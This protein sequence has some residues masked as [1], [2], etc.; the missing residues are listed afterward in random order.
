[1]KKDLMEMVWILDR[2]GSMAGLE[3]DTVGG[4]NSMVE[5]QRQLPGEVYVS[6]VLFNHQ[7]K[8][9]HDRVPIEKI[10]P[11]TERDYVP[12]G[13]TALIDAIGDAIHHIGNVHK[14]AREEDRPEKTLFIITTDGMENASR[15]YSAEEV[16]AKI[17]RQQE[18]YGWEFLFLGANIDAIET[19]R[20]Y[21]I[22]EDRSVNF[23]ADHDGVR[24]SMRSVTEAA[25]MMRMHAPLGSDWKAE[26]ERDF[27]GRSKNQRPSMKQILHG[28]RDDIVSGAWTPTPAKPW[29]GADLT[30]TDAAPMPDPFY[31]IRGVYVVTPHHREVSS[32][33]C[34]L[35]D[36]LGSYI[37]ADNKYSFYPRLGEA[38]NRVIADG[39]D[40]TTEILLAMLREADQLAE[41]R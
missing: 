31:G 17:R 14:Y 25:V 40:S 38:A 33:V 18:K 20:R 26:T 15:K 22:R 16:R 41:S 9:L 35:R 10:E 6:T 21:G 27:N 7:S 36:R 39:H 12:S 29:H 11:L 19:A 32:F 34:E 5:R 24:S 30:I 23:H 4:F 13:S 28:L 2:S 8:V 1:M 37:T 3:S